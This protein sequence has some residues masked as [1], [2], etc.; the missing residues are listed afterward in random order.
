[1]QLS[2]ISVCELWYGI[3]CRN[4]FYFQLVEIPVSYTKWFIAR[5]QNKTLNI[6]PPFPLWSTIHGV[7]CDKQY[8]INICTFALLMDAAYTTQT[9]Y[10]HHLI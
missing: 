10:C 9:G 5:N 6:T 3:G 2:Y 4:R 1:M 8:R 7:V